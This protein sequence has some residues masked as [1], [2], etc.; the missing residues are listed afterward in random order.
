M[1]Q[2]DRERGQRKFLSPL[3]DCAENARRRCAELTR[4]NGVRKRD[5]VTFKV[6]GR[7][8]VYSCG[9]TRGARHGGTSG[10]EAKKRE[11]FST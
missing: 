10:G 11:L 5:N 3:Q 1:G 2:W 7:G 9:R 8:V 6:G 4:E